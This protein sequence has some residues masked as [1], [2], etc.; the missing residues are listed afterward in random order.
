MKRCLFYGQLVLLAVGCSH[1]R[2]PNPEPFPESAV[3][4][5]DLILWLDYLSA[6]E[7][8]SSRDLKGESDRWRRIS[9]RDWDGDLRFGLVTAVQYAKNHSF[10]KAA[11]TIGQ[12]NAKAQGSAE[13]RTWLKFYALQLNTAAGLEKELGEE[14]RQR[15]EQEKKLRAL[16]DIEKDMSE[17]TRITVG[18]RPK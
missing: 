16:S 13:L 5:S 7:G 17:R 15:L 14:K 9:E 8:M 6:L 1:T 12:L 3:I 10:Q 2:S 4:R 11:E 18:P